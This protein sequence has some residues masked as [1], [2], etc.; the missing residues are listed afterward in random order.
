LARAQSAPDQIGDRIR[1]RAD[2]CRSRNELEAAYLRHFAT[3]ASA[4]CANTPQV[5][6]RADGRIDA[7]AVW[8][9]SDVTEIHAMQIHENCR[10]KILKSQSTGCPRTQSSETQPE[11]PGQSRGCPF[12]PNLQH[13]E[14][15]WPVTHRRH[16]LPPQ[17]YLRC[18]IPRGAVRGAERGRRQGSGT[19]LI[20]P[21]ALP[22]SW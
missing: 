18:A 11:P 6:Y 1:S 12:L 21:P 2:R 15:G 22:R 8:R 14:Y 19:K 13:G 5:A 3:I 7:L 16:R 20:R 10:H 9:P 17:R 4:A